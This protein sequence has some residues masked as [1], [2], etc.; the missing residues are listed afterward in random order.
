MQARG[1]WAEQT[2]E[3]RPNSRAS[4]SFKFGLDRGNISALAR[5]WVNRKVCVLGFSGCS[6]EGETDRAIAVHCERP[7]IAWGEGISGSLLQMFPIPFGHRVTPWWEK[8][9]VIVAV[10]VEAGNPISTVSIQVGVRAHHVLGLGWPAPVA[11]WQEPSSRVSART[12]PGRG[13]GKDHLR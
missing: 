3:A 11:G 13:A 12:K 5:V 2:R 6:S 8:G 7:S 10:L 4:Q 1:M 9:T